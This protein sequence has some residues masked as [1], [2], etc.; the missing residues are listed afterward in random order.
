MRFIIVNSGGSERGSD[1]DTIPVNSSTSAGISSHYSGLI[2]V[3]Q[4][5]QVPE[6][7]AQVDQ[8]HYSTIGDVEPQIPEHYG[9]V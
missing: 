7:Y 4:E 6:H 5:Q 2:D 9:A 8:Q 3:D 1:Y